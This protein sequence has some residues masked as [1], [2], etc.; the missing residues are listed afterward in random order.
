MP[1]W[2]ELPEELDPR[3]REFT[4]KL[5][6]L[7]DDAGL[8]TAAVADRI[9]YGTAAWERYLT[10]DALP[11]RAALT[12]LT[13]AVGT[14]PTA[15]TA[16]WEAA[17]RAVRAA[18]RQPAPTPTPRD[19][20]AGSAAPGVTD[21]AGPAAPGVAHMA[22]GAGSAASR[23]ADGA[24]SEPRTAGAAGSAAPGTADAAAPTPRTA[25]DAAA[26][27]ADPRPGGA[28]KG[29][30]RTTPLRAMT[31]PATRRAKGSAGASWRALRGR[32]ATQHGEP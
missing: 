19:G 1:R 30:P 27:A 23:V 22:D 32:L 31:G 16:H 13:A 29:A 8:S 7:I 2:D 11:P 6:E 3:V 28:P 24:A 9:G 25:A 5:R 4:E 10:G 18:R 20:G 26:V 12:A 17:D 21:G 14:D 15:L